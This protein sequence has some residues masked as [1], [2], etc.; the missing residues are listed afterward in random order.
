VFD[1]GAFFSVSIGGIPLIVIVMG[2]VTLCRKLKLSGKSLLIASL[3]IGFVLGMCYQM[4]TLMPKDFAGW[5][6][7]VV[8]S[9]ALGLVTSG[10]YETGKQLTGSDMIIGGT[11]LNMQL[12]IDESELEPVID[13]SEMEPVDHA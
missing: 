13:E 9:L 6:A 11:E 4:A 2:L 12:E 1:F 3:A 5:F 7:A 10:I 8:Y